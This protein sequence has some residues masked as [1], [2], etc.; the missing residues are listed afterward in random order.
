MAVKP[1]TPLKHLKRKGN[2]WYLQ[3]RVP[4]TLRHHPEF[5][6]K[7]VYTKSLKTS[8]VG[9]AKHRRDKR[10]QEIHALLEG[11]KSVEFMR[12]TEEFRRANRE[13]LS[14]SST[15]DE[16]GGLDAYSILIDTLEQEAQSKHRLPSLDS[17]ALPE[18]LRLRRDALVHAQKLDANS[19]TPTPFDYTPTL[20]DMMKLTIENKRRSGRKESS[21]TKYGP[22]ITT[23]LDYLGVG[24]IPMAKIRLKDA[25][26]YCQAMQ[27]NKSGSTVSGYMSSLSEV[28]KTARKQELVSGENPFKGCEI[29]DDGETALPW[30]EQQ[31]LDLYTLL[32]QQSQGRGSR[33]RYLDEDRLLFRLGCYTGARIEELHSLTANNL[34]EREG[35]EGRKFLSFSIKPADDGKNESAPRLVPVHPSLL[36]D[37]KTFRGFSGT[38]DAAGK[39]FGRV[40][41]SYLGDK[42]SRR[43]VFHSLRHY[44]ATEL[45]RAGFP[46][47]M[48]V[49]I[50]GHSRSSAPTELERTYI[51]GPSYQ[52]LVD[53]VYS[54][55]TLV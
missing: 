16:E 41:A 14:A 13:F 18:H 35:T 7:D 15:D 12:Q 2:T 29:K 11:S 43:Y 39:R 8:D 45:A 5:W 22:A 23:F 19:D 36:E 21:L 30:S 37:M 52:Q 49:F 38:A 9:I 31:I 6:G 25:H 53:A 27:T 47:S 20:Q 28:W 34:V 48:L 26:D 44:V 33:R 54:L 46:T 50:S 4:A 1:A 10:L 55:R 3:L 51:H 40:K 32:G 17:P 24:D 42:N